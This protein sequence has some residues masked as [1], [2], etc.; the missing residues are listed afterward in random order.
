VVN[1]ANGKDLK[2][3]E[4]WKI[5]ECPKPAILFANSAEINSL[6]VLA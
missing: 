2:G 4:V 6:A 5:A 1:S 3:E